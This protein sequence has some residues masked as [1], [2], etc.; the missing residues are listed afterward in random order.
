MPLYIVYFNL[1]EGVSE[2][3][4][5]QKYQAILD[6][7]NGKIEG[8]R[9]PKVYRHHLIGAHP[10]T[11]QIH[12][13]FDDFATWDRFLAFLAK[14]AKANKLFQEWNNLIDLNTLR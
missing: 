12:Q 8:I 3:E 10:R 11:Y 9:S 14:D 2:E 13:E 1:K 4:F 5:V 7:I 6:Y